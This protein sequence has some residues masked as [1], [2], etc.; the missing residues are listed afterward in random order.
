MVSYLSIV[1][2]GALG[3]L[4]FG[5][6]WP[7]D[8]ISPPQPMVAQTRQVLQ[9]YAATG[10]QFTERVIENAAHSPQIEKPE[11]FNALFHAFLAGQA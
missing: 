4:G 1:V 9:R 2:F 6:G 8:A 7:G 3:K 5:P 11:E 10:G